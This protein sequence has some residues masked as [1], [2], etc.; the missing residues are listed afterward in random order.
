MICRSIERAADPRHHLKRPALPQAVMDA[1]LADGELLRNMNRAADHGMQVYLV[2]QSEARKSNRIIQ[3]SFTDPYPPYNA[4][5]AEASKVFAKWLTK[6]RRQEEGS[7]GSEEDKPSEY[8]QVRQ[9]NM[10]KN[11]ARLAELGLGGSR[12]SEM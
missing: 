11:A 6:R 5:K 9:E 4:A 12:L 2:K 1:A 8:E 3:E 10:Q 7:S